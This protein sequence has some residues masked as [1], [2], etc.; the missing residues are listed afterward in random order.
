MAQTRRQKVDRTIKPEYVPAFIWERYQAGCDPC[1]RVY[2]GETLQAFE[3]VFFGEGMGL[4]WAALLKAADGE[5][6]KLNM[7]ETHIYQLSAMAREDFSKYLTYAQKAKQLEEVEKHG[8]LFL[9]A[10]Q[11]CYPD[12]DDLD[13]GLS[14]G[15]E[16]LE[17][18]QEGLEEIESELFFMRSDSKCK[19]TTT[20]KD[21]R[22][23]MVRYLYNSFFSMFQTTSL[24][25]PIARF[26]GAVLNE[27]LTREDVKND[28]KGYPVYGIKRGWWEE[29]EKGE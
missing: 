7:M 26:V 11:D 19:V 12:P 16:L 13:W 27:P 23:H 22:K 14:R 3:R 9:L 29:G 4:A 25:T 2:S 8:R 6:R 17:L 5:K 18:L 24:I 1:G 21:P 10:L 28:L 15:R 20:S